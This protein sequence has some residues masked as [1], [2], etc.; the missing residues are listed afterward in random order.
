MIK[1]TVK[2]ADIS[3]LWTRRRRVGLEMGRGYPLP[4]RLGVLGSIVTEPRPK[5]KFAQLNATETFLQG[6]M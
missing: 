4:S 3:G 1:I 2:V 5:T 6:G